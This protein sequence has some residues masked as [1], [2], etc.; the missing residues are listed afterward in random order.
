M[1]LNYVDFFILILQ[2]DFTVPESYKRFKV[3]VLKKIK[4]EETESAKKRAKFLQ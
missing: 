1:F 3:P 2:D 4:A